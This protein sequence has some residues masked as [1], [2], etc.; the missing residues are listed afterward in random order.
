VHQ[1][2]KHLLCEPFVKIYNESISTGIVPEI[3]KISRVTPV[4]KSGATTELGN[5]RPIAIISPFSRVLERL[6]YNKMFASLE[7]E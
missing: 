1:V 7:K 2:Y 6:I 5:Y 3:F 4:Y